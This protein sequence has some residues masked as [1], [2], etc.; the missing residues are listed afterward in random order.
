M[1]KVLL[2][3]LATLALGLLAGCSS[4]PARPPS[5]GGTKPAKAKPADEYLTGRIVFQK[6]FVTARAWAAD[7]QPFRLES[8]YT[9]GAPVAEGKA[10]IWRANFASPKG[11]SAKSYLWSGTASVED[12]RERGISPGLEDSF[13]P[14]NPSTHPFDLSFLKIDSDQAFEV[15]QEHGGKA[16]LK[17]TPEQPVLFALDWDSHTNKLVWHVVYGEKRADAKL[18]VA[19]DA[20]TGEFLKVEK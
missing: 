13:N 15:A 9:K 19:V 16:L 2:G 10:G 7:T 5:S 12:A 1:K 8:Q 18:T 17:K 3:I 20:S 11:R 4:E 14:S 6:L